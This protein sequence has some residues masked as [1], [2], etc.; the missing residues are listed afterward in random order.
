MTTKW[1][2]KCYILRVYVLVEWS[3]GENAFPW[4]F[5]LFTIS[6]GSSPDTDTAYTHGTQCSILCHFANQLSVELIKEIIP[7]KLW[8]LH[9]LTA[10]LFLLSFSYGS[11][12][13]HPSRRNCSMLLIREQTLQT[14]N[15]RRSL[16][17]PSNVILSAVRMQRAVCTLEQLL[18]CCTA[19]YIWDVSLC[20]RIWHTEL[21]APSYL[22]AVLRSTTGFAKGLPWM[23]FDS[24][25]NS[26][27]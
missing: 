21:C 26:E 3:W 8:L 7:S 19:I 6:P 1:H 13:S 20:N 25:L 24:Q 10:S 4:S 5:R 16:G 2:D 14:L 9:S 12:L 22:A 15:P 18:P 27:L 17:M 23:S 11:Q